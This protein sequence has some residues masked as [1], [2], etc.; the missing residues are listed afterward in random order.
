MVAYRHAMKRRGIMNA[1]G[2]RIGIV[3]F[4]VAWMLLPVVIA[5]A[6]DGPIPAAAF[7]AETAGPGAFGQLTPS[8]AML[9]G[10]TSAETNG[11][12]APTVP[13]WVGRDLLGKDPHI[14]APLPEELG[15]QFPIPEGIDP[16]KIPG[17]D[18]PANSGPDD[19]ADRSWYILRNSASN[20]WCR[21]QHWDHF[22]QLKMLQWGYDQ[23]A[24]H[25]DEGMEMCRSDENV[26]GGAKPWRV[27]GGGIS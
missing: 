8:T 26:K 20:T 5:S 4:V 24:P 1:K 11:E 7:S 6:E 12:L 16:S 18:G 3:A 22:T 17:W 14:F 2:T 10:P 9:P 19:D 15:I 23:P 25:T 27:A 13:V 21:P